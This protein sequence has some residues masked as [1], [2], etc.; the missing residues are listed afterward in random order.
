MSDNLIQKRICNRLNVKLLDIKDDGM[1]PIKFT[2][3]ATA[4]KYDHIHDMNIDDVIVNS[5]CREIKKKEN[6]SA[7]FF[8]EDN[9]IVMVY[10]K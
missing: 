6:I 8:E 4:E 10:Y 1:L 9:E 5:V 3:Q 7:L 2:W